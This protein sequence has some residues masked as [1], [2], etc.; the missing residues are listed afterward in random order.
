MRERL[1]TAASMD[2]NHG[3][4]NGPA[5]EFLTSE[6]AAKFLNVSHSYLA[7][8]RSNGGGPA[9]PF[10]SRRSS[11]SGRSF[12]AFASRSAVGAGL[13]SVVD[14]LPH[15]QDAVASS[16]SSSTRFLTS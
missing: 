9:L 16:T 1:L 14:F 2:V 13:F 3:G 8:L 7:A 12:A 6:Q 15:L 10:E 11:P 4:A 5:P